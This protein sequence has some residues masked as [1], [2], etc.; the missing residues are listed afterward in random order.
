MEIIVRPNEV[1]PYK[2]AH[3]AS[4]AVWVELALRKLLSESLS[5]IPPYLITRF[6]C[7]YKESAKADE[8]LTLFLRLKKEISAL[9]YDF[10]FSIHS[11]INKRELANGRLSISLS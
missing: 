10:F 4:Y 8:K 2:I 7:K 3:H 5:V 1:D 9:E 6:E 11:D